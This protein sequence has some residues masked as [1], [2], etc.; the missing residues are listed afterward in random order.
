M[1][2]TCSFTVRGRGIFPVDMLRYDQCAPVFPQDASNL[3]LSDSDDFR[4]IQLN[5]YK[6][7]PTFARWS[8]F[9]WVIISETV[10]YYDED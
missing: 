7:V 9:G 3:L 10:E 6:R 8:S 4:D 2:N 5:C 1:K